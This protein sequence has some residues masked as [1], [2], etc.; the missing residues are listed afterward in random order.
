[1]KRKVPR[2]KP[3]ST[4]EVTME[5]SDLKDLTLMNWVQLEN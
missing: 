4:P 5:V 3:Q 2:T 1:M